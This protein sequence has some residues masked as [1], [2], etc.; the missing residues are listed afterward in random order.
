M[1]GFERHIAAAML[2]TEK[3]DTMDEDRISGT[4]NDLKGQVKE[5]VGKLTGDTKLN[6][7]GQADQLAGVAQRTV[8]KARDAVRDA[9]DTVQDKAT[10]L[11][12]YLDDTIHE[13][14][15][16]AL[17]AAGAVGYVLSLLVHRH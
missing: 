7:E 8:G 4:A 12:E 5:G 16:T 17:L 1:A 3:E 6:V 14:P 2:A 15:L 10:T 11:G 13:R 9:A